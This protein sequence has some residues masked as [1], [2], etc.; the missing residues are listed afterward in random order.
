V[1]SKISAGKSPPY[2]QTTDNNETALFLGLLVSCAAPAV[3]ST[4]G[5]FD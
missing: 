5:I 4:L 3:H 1:I 2:T